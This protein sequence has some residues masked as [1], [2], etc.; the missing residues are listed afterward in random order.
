MLPKFLESMD[1]DNNYF[2][3]FFACTDQNIQSDYFSVDKLNGVLMAIITKFFPSKLQY[4]IFSN[5]HSSK[6]RLCTLR[7]NTHRNLVR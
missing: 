2:N 3:H 6:I 7:F 1:P 5:V 4:S